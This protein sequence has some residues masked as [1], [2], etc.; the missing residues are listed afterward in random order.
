MADI[1]VLYPSV[2]G[3]GPA[4]VYPQMYLLNNVYQG[5][6]QAC[7]SDLVAPTFAGIATLAVQSR[8][9][10]RA[11]WAAATDPTPPIRYEVYIKEAT[12][13]GLF[14]L[15]N[16][17]AITPNLQYDIFFLPDGSLLQNGATYYVGV[18]AID[19]VSNRDSNVVNMN[20]ISTGVSVDADKYETRGVFSINDNNDFQGTLW[21]LKNSQTGNGATLGVAAYQVYD[22]AGLPIGGMFENNI[23]A[24]S[25]GQFIITPIPSLLTEA[26]DHYVVKVSI[27]MDSAIRE[28]YVPILRKEAEYD[29]FGVFFLNNDYEA[30]GTFWVS[31]DEKVVTSGLGLGSW[32]VYDDDGN[33]IVGF[34]GAGI[35]PTAAGIYA[36]VPFPIPGG[37]DITRAYSIKC[38]IPVDGINRSEMIP[39]QGIRSQ[40][41]CRAQF[42]INALNQF[43]ATLWSIQN[44]E[45]T[46]NTLLGNASYTVYDVNGT[47]VAGLSESGLTPD[48]NGMYH[49]TP[50]SASLLTDLTHYTVRVEINVAGANRVSYRGFTLLGT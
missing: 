36:I 41:E 26:L 30:D 11:T 8:G 16:I 29:I 50:V 38:T 47:L 48:G 14:N 31:K 34:G 23:S 18:R 45:L 37:T 17:V 10:I 19:G 27:V 25:Q 28:D 21:I 39:V 40:Y 2:Q 6:S 20:L 42:S 43:Q 9:Q 12:N 46:P 15:T 13:V 24:N 33:A 3:S 32:Q 5:S 7:I 1:L 44:G 35:T 49:A 4:S 22:S